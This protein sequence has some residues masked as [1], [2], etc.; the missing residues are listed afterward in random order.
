[1]RVPEK[2]RQCV[3]FVGIR[4]SDGIKWGGTAFTVAVLQ[5]RITFWYLVTAK[6]VA[7]ATSGDCLIRMNNRDNVGVIYDAGEVHWWN[8][9]TEPDIVD[10][11]VTTFKPPAIL[12]IQTLTISQEMFATQD[13]IKDYGI[14]I[15]DEVYIS[16]LFTRVTETAKIHPVLRTGTIAMMPDEKIH[17]PRLGEIEAYLIE[18]RSIGGLS[19][20][21]VFVRNTVSTPILD[22]PDRRL[23]GLGQFRFLG[24]MIGHWQIPPNF[25]PTLSEAVN[26]GLSA[27]VPSYKLTEVLN[28]PELLE[29][30]KQVVEERKKQAEKWTSLDSSFGTQTTEQ[31]EEIPPKGCGRKIYA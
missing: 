13:S 6:H 1:M 16:G 15:G 30:R 7:D 11:S 5:D 27:I 10:V 17:F 31:G 23:Y 29:M 22:A 8:H 19:G 12:R 18:T 9:P 2:L 28:H 3:G 21:P 26:M 24:S 4:Q 14:G 25:D 20:C